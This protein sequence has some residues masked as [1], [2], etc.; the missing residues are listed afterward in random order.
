MKITSLITAALLLTGATAATAHE[1]SHRMHAQHM[2]GPLHDKAQMDRMAHMPG[3]FLE[4]RQI[5]G[6]DVS[7][8]AMKASESM[9]H[10]GS[11]NFMIKVERN[12]QAMEHIAVNSKVIHPDGKAES[13]M[14]NAMGDWYMAGYDLDDA[15]THQLMV[16][17]KTPDGRKHRGG[18]YYPAADAS[19]QEGGSAAHH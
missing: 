4:H 5:D 6:Y 7:F 18:V 2:H 14:M 9:R 16:L 8:H 13:K 19:M 1:D 10:G 11:F 17:F 15:G 12:G 3:T